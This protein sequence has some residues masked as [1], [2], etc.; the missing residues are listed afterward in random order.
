MGWDEFYAEPDYGPYAHNGEKD[1]YHDEL[2]AA[3]AE[4]S[5][6]IDYGWA[7]LSHVPY[8][9]N[10]KGG[11]KYA[12][13]KA[14]GGPRGMFKF[15]SVDDRAPTSD[16]YNAEWAIQKI[17]QWETSKS[18]DPWLLMVGFVKPHTPCVMTMRQA[19][20]GVTYCTTMVRRSF[21]I[22]RMTLMNKQTLLKLMPQTQPP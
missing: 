15:N 8:A 3:L 4:I 11:W 13:G 1:T 22:K 20:S 16:E 9:N 6:S 2:P 7:R 10:P 18:E 17:Q 14:K 5:G 12:G 21:T 19:T